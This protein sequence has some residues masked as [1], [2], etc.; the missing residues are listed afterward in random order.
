MTRACTRVPALA[1]AALLAAGAL[2]PALAA[3]QDRQRLVLAL[4][5]SN[6][7]RDSFQNQ[8]LVNCNLFFTNGR[9]PEGNPQIADSVGPPSG[10][11]DFSNRRGEVFVR[12][13]GWQIEPLPPVRARPT[14]FADVGIELQGRTVF[15]TSRITHGRRL[16]AAARRSRI[17]IVRNAKREDGALLTKERKPDANTAPRRTRC[18]TR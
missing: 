4:S 12:R 14:L 5:L 18:S 8:L 17:A 16:T 10:T 7:R 13:T 6:T 1:I 9:S 2:A 15:I 3:A 11:A